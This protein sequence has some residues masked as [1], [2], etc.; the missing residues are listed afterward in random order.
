MG[1]NRVSEMQKTLEI[2]GNSNAIRFM[3]T[4]L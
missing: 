4:L 1:T 3:K 2:Q